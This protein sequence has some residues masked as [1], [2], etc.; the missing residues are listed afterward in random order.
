MDCIF[1][2]YTLIYFSEEDQQKAIEAISNKLKKGG[3]LIL[4]SAMGLRI[5]SKSLESFNFERFKLF[6]KL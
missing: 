6:R 5:K 4:D 3:I 2:R 1:C